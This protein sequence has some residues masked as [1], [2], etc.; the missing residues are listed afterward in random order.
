MYTIAIAGKGGTGKTTLAGI[1]IRLIIKKNLGSILAVD[2]DPNSTLND[3]LGVNLNKSI[4]EIIDEINQGNLVVPV[5]MSKETFIEYEIHNNLTESDKFDLLVMGRPEGPGCYCYA[6][7]L[8]RGILSKISKNY[9]YIVIDNEA[10]LEHLSR[11]TTREADIFL[12]IA[13]YTQA[14]INTAQRINDLISELKIKTKKKYLIFNRF[15]GIIDKRKIR[16]LDLL[17]CIPFDQNIFRASQ[18]GKSIFDIE[19]GSPAIEAMDRIFE[20][21]V[22]DGKFS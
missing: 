17:G 15:D 9:N 3:I 13:D 16:S 20:R 8:L 18:E 12:I 11:K 4:G 2:A 6:N 1:I 22:Q 7:N 21:I 5:G 10:G 14:G 19:E